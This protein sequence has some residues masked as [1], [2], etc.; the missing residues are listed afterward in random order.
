MMERCKRCDGGNVVQIY[1]ELSCLQC[2]HA[3][4]GDQPAPRIRP[5]GR[6]DAMENTEVYDR[7]IV[8]AQ[9]AGWPVASMADV[10]RLAA[11]PQMTMFPWQGENRPETAETEQAA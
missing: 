11:D 4:D 1:G 2:G 3:P 10:R 5:E 8:A 6:P 9:L 7:R